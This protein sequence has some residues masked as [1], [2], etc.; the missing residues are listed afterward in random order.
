MCFNVF[1][2]LV[3]IFLPHASRSFCPST[4]CVAI[5]HDTIHKCYKSSMA[6]TQSP[7]I[8]SGTPLMHEISMSWAFYPL[9]RFRQSMCKEY[10]NH[11]WRA[12]EGGACMKR[13]TRLLLHS[14]LAAYSYLSPTN[15]LSSSFT[16]SCYSFNSKFNLI[17]M[18]NRKISTFRK[19][20][21]LFEPIKLGLMTFLETCRFR[22]M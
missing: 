15:K 17:E 21:Q 14:P 22:I 8:R 2:V 12:L 11:V 16:V 7:G 5:R 9:M 3:C 19:S 18:S 10:D 1:A 20:V 4:A 13:S 6:Q